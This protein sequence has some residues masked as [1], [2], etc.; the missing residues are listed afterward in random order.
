MIDEPPDR[1]AADARRYTDQEV[2][3]VI[4]RA[5]EWQVKETE[6][7]ESSA[8]GLSL[9]E[10]E[11]VAREAGLDPALVRRAAVDLDT[12]N[13]TSPHSHFLGAPS[14]ISIE[15]TIRGEIS[16]DEYEPIVEELR[17]AFN[18]NG[19]PSTLGRS[20]AWTSMQSSR[21]RHQGG[22]S[23]NVT[24]SPRGGNTVI[25]AEESL[26]PIAGGL[27]GGLMGGI[28]GGTTGLTVTVGLNVMHSAMFAGGLW[29][30]V[31]GG[32]YLL[33]R[34][35]FGHVARGRGDRLRA[36]VDRIAEHVVQTTPIDD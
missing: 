35:I 21:G 22:R 29:L 23:V 18:D 8:T 4:K 6:R 2:A 14:I 11:Q 1:G 33:A 36:V 16:S 31:L 5:A 26:R 15:R 10:L 25:R 28:G 27:F 17:R 3:L 20:L 7:T 30:S 13:S 12:R 32:S 19:F 24:V 9:T 34:T